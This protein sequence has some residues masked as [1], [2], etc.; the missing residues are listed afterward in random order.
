MGNP[1]PVVDTLIIDHNTFTHNKGFIA[2]WQL[3]AVRYLQ[4]TNNLLWNPGL[5]GSESRSKRLWK[6]V[7]YM[8]DS[9]VTHTGPKAL[10]IFGLTE[11]ALYNTEVVMENNNLFLDPVVQ[12]KYDKYEAFERMPHWNNELK[13]IVDNDK[14]VY[15]EALVLVNV[16]PV[17]NN[18]EFL[19]ESF[20][21]LT[22]TITSEGIVKIFPYA[23]Q[24]DTCLLHKQPGFAVDEPWKLL[25]FA[26]PAGSI[27]Y[28][29]A[30]GGF[31]VGDLNWFPVKKQE[32]IDAGEPVTAIDDLGQ[33]M[34]GEYT[35]KQNYPNPFNPST[36]IS[37]S[38]PKAGHVNISIYNTLGQ[39]VRTLV[40]QK[41]A[42]GAQTA[43]WNGFS[44]TG[45][46]VATG[47]Y[48]YQMNAGSHV[49]VKKML[50]IK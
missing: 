33:A 11:V 46:F 8:V 49:M 29:K 32:W 16:P 26:Y 34:P 19:D 23:D 10:C 6:E 30:A 3:N 36:T 31:P 39:K 22:D 27:S 5:Y 43:V 17:T 24:A 21:A 42:A 50:L 37:Y 28:T 25:D 7:T 15:E 4:I 35:L 18:L 13:E 2:P 38:L 12:A 45:S 41:M 20:Y 40:D 47:V 14:A 44:D 9:V 48:F 1:S